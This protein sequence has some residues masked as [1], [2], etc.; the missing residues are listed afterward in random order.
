MYNPNN[1]IA[2]Q[3]TLGENTQQTHQMP[4]KNTV[5]SANTGTLNYLRD[6]KV[7]DSELIPEKAR[8]VVEEVKEFT[9][10]DILGIKT[11]NWNT[12]TYVDKMKSYERQVPLD[13]KKFEIRSG[14]R[15]EN[16]V[17]IKSKNTYEGTDSRNN[18]TGWNVSVEVTTKELK[19]NYETVNSLSKEKAKR[20]NSTLL[21]KGKYTRP[22]AMQQTF[23]QQ[24]R[25]EKAKE[26]ELRQKIRQDYLHECPSASK[27]KVEANVFKRVAQLKLKQKQAQQ[28]QIISTEETFKPNMKK[29]IKHRK[30]KVYYHD[31]AWVHSQVAQKEAWS[32]CMNEDYNSKGCCIKKRDLDRWQT[33]L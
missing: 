23:I 27:E 26:D 28:A 32:C 21:E 7:F 30:V 6:M 11:P 17:P 5:G 2:T 4:A 15:D 10:K 19:K 1:Y 25:E 18:Y 24:A 16:P 29:T 31:G 13:K 14:L 22:E 3:T 33:T 8:K 20:A 9:A 12:S